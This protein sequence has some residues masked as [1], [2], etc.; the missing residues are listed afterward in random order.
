MSRTASPNRRTARVLMY[1]AY[2]DPEY[3][4]AALQ[5]LT[6]ARE[7]RHRGHH[8]EFVTNRWPGLRETGEVEGFFVRRLEP[9]RWRKHREFRLWFN[10]SRYLWQRRRD[11][12]IVHSHGAYYTHAFIGPLSRAAGLK[13]LV[14]ASLANDDLLD[15]NLP[16]IGYLHRMML[17]RIDAYVGISE[18]LVQEFRAGSLDPRKIHH[19]P[20]GVDTGLFQPCPRDRRMALREKLGLPAGQPVALYVGVLDQRK[21]IEWLAEQ[22][23][24]HHA[25]GTNGLLLAVG[26]QSREDADGALRG[27]LAV[28]GESH[29]GLFVLRDFS[30]DILA[31][32]Q[33]ADALVLPSLKEGLPNVV[34]EAMACGLPCVAARAS[35]SRELIRE[36]ETGYTYAHG[37]VTEMGEALRR[38]LSAEGGRLGGNAREVALTQYSI[39]AIADRY[40]ALY[41]QLL[42]QR[43]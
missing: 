9:G 24:R 5:A 18:D 23:I 8:V 25:F 34:L 39:Q 11:F 20:N 29:P 31:Y 10:L 21:N 36:G 2:F 13:S 32:Y 7:L 22:W 12:D 6:L 17:R 43:R 40:E 35:G 3:S 14:K 30:T 37:D 28:L 42:T 33:S 15:L 1:T 27:R 41:E 38:C 26:P 19:I 4:G 16:L